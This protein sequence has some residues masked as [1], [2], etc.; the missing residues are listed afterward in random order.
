MVYKQGRFGK[1]LACP[2]FPECRN[3]KAI[4]KEL[5]VPCPKCGGKV[6]VRKSKKGATFYTCD[7]SPECDFISWD[8]PTAEKC[9]QCGGALMKVRAFK[10]R[11]P[12]S[13]KCFNEECGYVRKPEA[14]KKAEKKS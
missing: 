5:D 4:T 12:V 8:E 13:Y 6:I 11:G 10:R 7:H 1:F 2:G 9:P 14:K 3:T